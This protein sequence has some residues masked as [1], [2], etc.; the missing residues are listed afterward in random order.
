MTSIAPQP[1]ESLDAVLRARARAGG[2]DVAIL[3]FPEV[4]ILDFAGPYEVFTVAARLARRDPGVALAP[5]RVWT[6]AAQAGRVA[7]RHGLNV[8]ADHGFA[9][10]PRADLVIAPG[11]VVT[12]PLADAATLAWLAGAARDA[13][14]VASV[15]TGAFLLG[16]LGLLDGRAATTHWEDVPDLR[17]ACP[18]AAVREDVP[19]VDEDAIVTSAGISAGIGMSLHLVG[20]ILGRDH[21]IRT[22]RQMQYD[23]TT[24]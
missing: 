22:A 16:R 18:A 24:A 3:L 17:A 12:Q 21:A 1:A 13:R 15:C 23:W 11:G 5:F 2:L 19:F 14:L 7:A 10:A 20:R 6:V 8:V 9:D 4:E